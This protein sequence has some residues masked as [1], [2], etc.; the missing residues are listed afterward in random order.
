MTRE[1]KH[2]IRER[3]RTTR[4]QKKLDELN[5][6]CSHMTAND[7]TFKVARR[8]IRTGKGP[9]RCDMGWLECELRGYCNGDC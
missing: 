8:F 5:A 9:Y 2:R 7:V 6:I 3:Q 4:K 1:E